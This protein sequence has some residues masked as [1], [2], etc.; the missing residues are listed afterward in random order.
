MF[1]LIQS[2]CNVIEYKRIEESDYKESVVLQH[3][4]G[5]WELLIL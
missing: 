2:D 1:N 4:H 3:I 5:Q